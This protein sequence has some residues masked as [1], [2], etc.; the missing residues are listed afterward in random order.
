[1]ALVLFRSL[2][3]LM[4]ALDAHR[5]LRQSSFVACGEHERAARGPD[6]HLRKALVHGVALGTRPGTWTDALSFEEC[7]S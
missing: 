6:A 1:M 3:P 4:T 5:H 7:I 2:E